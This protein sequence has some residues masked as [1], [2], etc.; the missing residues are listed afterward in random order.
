[1]SPHPPADVICLTLADQSVGTL[2]AFLIGLVVGAAVV[3]MLRASLDGAPDD[4]ARSRR[5][6]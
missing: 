2:G 6:S 3:T 1:M 4:A 5:A